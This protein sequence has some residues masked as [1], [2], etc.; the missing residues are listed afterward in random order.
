MRSNQTKKNV[1]GMKINTDRVDQN[2]FD[3]RIKYG[4]DIHFIFLLL[5]KNNFKLIWT[6][7]FKRLV[8]QNTLE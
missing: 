3:C 5:K 7:F 2:K 8:R 6:A 4:Q 1:K